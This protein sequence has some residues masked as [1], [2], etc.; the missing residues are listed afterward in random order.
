MSALL[1]GRGLTTICHRC[2]SSACVSA[3][4]VRARRALSSTSEPPRPPSASTATTNIERA[5]RYVEEHGL[6][7]RDERD[8]GKEAAVADERALPAVKKNLPVVKGAV[9]DAADI[10]RILE[11]EHGAADVVVLEVRDKAPFT[12]QIV[13]CTARSST[14][15]RA[16]ADGLT[17]DL[18]ALSVTLDGELVQ[19]CG[20]ES[21][22]WM[23]VDVGAVVVHI[24]T[25]SARQRYDLEGLWLP[26]A[27]PPRL[28]ILGTESLSGLGDTTETRGEMDETA[29]R[30]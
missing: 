20:R 8:W 12:N 9:P 5:R 14:H 18:R 24:M 27:A 17:A 26:R 7:S 4:P 23:A 6:G 11:M 10:S 21:R 15:V 28:D 1:R 13:V 25:E 3:V 2:T 29:A 16:V 22:D 30:L 19:V